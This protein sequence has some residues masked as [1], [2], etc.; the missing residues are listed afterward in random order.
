MTAKREG[1]DIF[2]PAAASMPGHQQLF[3][4]SGQPCGMGAL[5]PTLCHGERET[6]ADFVLIAA[7]PTAA[8]ARR[9]GAV[10]G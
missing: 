7:L 10:L 2:P 9:A 3:V 1:F 8:P 6:L 4:C 5:T